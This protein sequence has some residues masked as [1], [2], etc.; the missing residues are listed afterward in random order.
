M[1]IG[2]RLLPLAACCLAW[3]TLHVPQVPVYADGSGPAHR[4]EPSGVVTGPAAGPMDAAWEV[5]DIG[6]LQDRPLFTPGRRPVP[7]EPPSP[8]PDAVADRMDEAANLPLV[9]GIA[10]SDDKAV[11]V[12]KADALLHRVTVGGR[13]GRWTVTTIDRSAV[14]LQWAERR[15]SLPVTPASDDAAAGRQDPRPDPDPVADP[16][17]RPA[18]AVKWI[19]APRDESFRTG[20]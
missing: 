9:L 5:P 4:V 19:I 17:D 13:I 8:A 11:A 12:L 20:W 6:V 7:G 14:A 1:S 2:L 15:V 18:P 10:V 16:G 3:G